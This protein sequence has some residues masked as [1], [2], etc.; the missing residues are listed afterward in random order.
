MASVP[1]FSC[2]PTCLGVGKF[3]VYILVVFLNVTIT[4][5]STIV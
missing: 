2:V 4:A 3:T 5:V 1:M